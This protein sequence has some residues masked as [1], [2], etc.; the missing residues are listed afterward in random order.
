[1]SEVTFHPDTAAASP[2]ALEVRVG[3]GVIYTLMPG[4][5]RDVPQEHL[6]PVLNAIAKAAPNQTVATPAAGTL[7]GSGSSGGATTYTYTLVASND[8][9]DTAQSATVSTATG[10]ASLSAGTPIVITFPSAPTGYFDNW[11]VIRTVGG[12]SQG[13]IATVAKSATSASDTGQAASP[14]PYVN[15]QATPGTISGTASANTGTGGGV[16]LT[17]GGQ[18]WPVNGLVGYTVTMG[19]VTLVVTSND[20]THLNG[21]AWSGS[22]PAAGAYSLAP[23]SFGMQFGKPADL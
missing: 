15:P 9:G 18:S 5:P 3:D 8:Q 21:V 13:L 4:V 2:E 23:N 22:T 20:A 1:M 10:Q 12:S 11:K 16:G 6:A 17:D 14:A 19:G 7:S